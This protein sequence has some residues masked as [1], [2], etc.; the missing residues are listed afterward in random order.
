MF[1]LSSSDSRQQEF[2]IYL[3]PLKNCYP[4]FLLKLLKSARNSQK[5]FSLHSQ[6]A[7]AAKNKLQKNILYFY[8]ILT[9]DICD[10]TELYDFITRENMF[11]EVDPKAQKRY[12]SHQCLLKLLG[13]AGATTARK[14]MITKLNWYITSVY[15]KTIFSFDSV[16]R[17]I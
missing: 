8:C 6:P 17:K 2:T 10:F 16:V 9:F 15:F 14:I 13:S 4:K 3:G 7:K 1:I 5:L 11:P 12:S